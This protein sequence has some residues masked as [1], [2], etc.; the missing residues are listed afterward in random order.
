[1]TCPRVVVAG[2]AFLSRAARLCIA[3][4]TVGDMVFDSLRTRAP[5][6]GATGAAI[7]RTR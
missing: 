2:T 6:R 3:Q 5:M 7:I 4:G 1:M